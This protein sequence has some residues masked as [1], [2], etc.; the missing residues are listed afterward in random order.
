MKEMSKVKAFIKKSLG[1]ILL[2]K[3]I[4]SSLHYSLIANLNFSFQDKEYLY[5]VLDYLPGGDLRYYISNLILSLK[6][7]HSNNILHRDIKPENLVFDDKGYIHLTDFGISRKIKNGKSIL[8]KSGTPGYIS[9]EVLLNKPQGFSSDFFS[10]G[11]ICYELLLG[12]KPFKGKNKKEIA[13]KILY[14]NIKLTKK[15]IPENYSIIMGDFINKLLKRNKHERLGNKSIDEIMNH[16]WLEGVDWKIIELKLVDSE[17]IPFVPSIGDNFDSNVA[18]K[19]D[20]MNMEHYEE[21]LKKI[22]DSGYFKHFYFNYYSN[23]NISKTKLIHEKTSISH[24]YTTVTEGMKSTPTQSEGDPESN[25][26]SIGN[27]NNIS[28]IKSISIQNFENNSDLNKKNGQTDSDFPKKSKTNY[29]KST[30]LLKKRIIYDKGQFHEMNKSNVSKEKEGNE[31]F[32]NNEYN[33]NEKI[34]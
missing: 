33:E 21:N 17:Y 5:L 16:S 22:N 3:Q 1:S 9:P 7:I 13:E 14:K 34:S 30:S 15:D 29:I 6:Y 32:I 23:I 2:E 25:D 11:V 8:N 19:K 4:L 12:K 20:N 28:L 24:K 31:S 10:V 27:N 26:I 18:N